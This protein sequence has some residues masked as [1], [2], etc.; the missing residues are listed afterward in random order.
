MDHA[1][2]LRR[3]VLLMH[4]EWFGLDYA[5]GGLVGVLFAFA[6]LGLLWRMAAP[7][8]EESRRSWWGLA[9]HLPIASIHIALYSG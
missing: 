3:L 9:G 5:V 2:P 1:Q 4:Y 8:D 7:G 6:N